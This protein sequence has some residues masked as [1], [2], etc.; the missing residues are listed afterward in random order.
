[1]AMTANRPV[2][3]IPSSA[4]DRCFVDMK[5]GAIYV[6]SMVAVDDLTPG[7]AEEAGAVAASTVIGVLKYGCR[8][9]A[10]AA[11]DGDIRIQVDTGVFGPFKNG[12]GPDLLTSD[13][14]LDV[15]WCVQGDTAAK[16]DGGGT[17]PPAGFVARVDDEGVWIDFTRAAELKLLRVKAVIP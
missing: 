4:A 6:G 7:F 17:R 12:A 13:H 2:G 5:A 15:C 3:E 16:T 14:V 10:I 11:N 8:S 9:E 1:M